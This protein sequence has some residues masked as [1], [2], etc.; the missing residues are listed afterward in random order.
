MLTNDAIAETWKKNHH[1]YYAKSSKSRKLA[2][3]I[4]YS[5]C[6]NFIN[7]YYLLSKW[8]LKSKINIQHSSAKRY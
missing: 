7:Y 8:I 1:Y 3:E 2:K 5:Y 4:V 6:R